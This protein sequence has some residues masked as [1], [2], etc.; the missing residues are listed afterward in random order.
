MRRL[1]QDA[2]GMVVFSDG[3]NGGGNATLIEREATVTLLQAQS[4]IQ[5]SSAHKRREVQQDK[6]GPSRVGTSPRTQTPHGDEV[7]VEARLDCS[8]PL[9]GVAPFPKSFRL[10]AC[11]VNLYIGGETSMAKTIKSSPR[12]V[13]VGAGFGGLTAARRIARLPVQLTVIDRKNHHTFQ[14]LLYQVAT[15]GLSPGEIAAPIRWI[16][17]ASANVEV[18]LEEVVDFNL[19]Q[20]KV[21]TSDKD[22]DY[23]FLV[24]ASGSTHT[25]FGHDEWEPLA[26]GLKTIEDATEIRRRVLLAFELA[27][28]QAADAATSPPLQFVVVGG[29]PTGVEL[30]GTLAEI[31]RHS[32]NHQ[33]RNIDP[34]QTRV[35]LIE[36]GPRVLPAY[37]EELSR[38]AETQLQHLGVEVRTSRMVNRIE[39]GAVWSGDQ[40]IPAQ[41]VLW[42]AGVAASPLGRKLGVSVD[43]A[44][45]VLVEP[46]LSIPGH[47]QIFVIGDLAALHDEKG[48]PLP[49]LAPVAIQEGDCVAETI[50]RDLE[51]QPRRKFHYHDKGSLATIGRAAAVAQIGNFELS[52]YFAW[53]AWLF[54]HIFFLIG[55]RNR[56]LVM[57]QWAWSYLTYERGARLITGSDDLPGWTE[58]SSQQTGGTTGAPP[59]PPGGGARLNANHEPPTVTAQSPG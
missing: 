45:R 49:G 56:L 15:A 9:P 47:P 36:G 8:A 55:F 20:K 2:S 5:E 41:V 44:G 48:K 28:R 23:D 17:R 46:D 29:G 21:I 16:L 6:S 40:K 51:N 59:V 7:F 27:E 19:E 32:M 37:S 22:I 54:V 10:S 35:L 13:I 39:P 31:T 38:K 4:G 1:V 3:A 30:A 33:F 58:A 18:L 53:L 14:P 34:R 25:Y 11:Y 26:P 42:A 12:V 24:V 52:G 43:R 50:A 57:I